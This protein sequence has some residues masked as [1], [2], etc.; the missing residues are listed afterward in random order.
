MLCYTT[1]TEQIIRQDLSFE[2]SVVLISFAEFLQKLF[3]FSV[4]Q[5]CLQLSVNS[6]ICHNHL[7]YAMCIKIHIFYKAC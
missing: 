7:K 3:S 2:K 6:I 4:N 1:R 5:Q